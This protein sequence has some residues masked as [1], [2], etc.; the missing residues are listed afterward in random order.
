MKQFIN[1]HLCQF[2]PSTT[3]DFWRPQTG[4]FSSQTQLSPSQTQLSPA[5]TQLSPAQTQLPPGN[6]LAASSGDASQ[7]FLT[8]L[9]NELGPMKEQ[10]THFGQTVDHLTDK[11]AYLEAAVDDPD[12]ADMDEPEED[13][14]MRL[15][16]DAERA[17]TGET[18]AD[19]VT[20]PARRYPLCTT[21]DRHTPYNRR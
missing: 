6:A 9:R 13:E 11:M 21:R 7:L 5:Q 1:N 4:L 19:Q 12:F 20:A 18:D 17:H 2:F 3:R 14:H 16:E 15:L 10:L 8:L